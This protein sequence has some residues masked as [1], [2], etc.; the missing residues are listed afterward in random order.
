[1]DS[2]AVLTIPSDSQML[3]LYLNKNEDNE[4]PTAFLFLEFNSHS[5]TPSLPS[6]V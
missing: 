4:D 1:M 2:Q 6:T 3:R 5:D